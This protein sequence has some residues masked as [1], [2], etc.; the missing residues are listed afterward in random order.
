VAGAL[1]V[2]ALYGGTL[3]KHDLIACALE[4]ERAASGAAHA[5][6][7]AP[8]VLGGIVLIRSYHPL[9]IISLPVPETLRVVVVHPHCEVVTAEARKLVTARRFEIA[10]AVANLGNV[11]ALVTALHRGDLAL[12]GRSIHDALVE[13]IR[14]P[15]VP[16]FETVKR[17]ALDAGACGCSLSGSGPSV[18]AF[19]DS[20]G[21]AQCIGAAMQRAFRV[22]AHL[23]SDLYAGPVNTRG[24]MVL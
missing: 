12:L 20:D 24:A 14:A 15:L 13:P 7:V 17:A 22:Q 18:F 16:G 1:A 23:E 19:A 5:D 3:S 9:D 6:N 11:A 8:S 4:G 21:A 10:E 2:D